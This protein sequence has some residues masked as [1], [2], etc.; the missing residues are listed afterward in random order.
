MV[1]CAVDSVTRMKVLHELHVARAFLLMA[2][3]IGSMW[4]GKGSPFCLAWLVNSAADAM[5]SI[6]AMFC[7]IMWLLAI[8][9]DELCYKRRLLRI[10][11]LIF[12]TSI[13]ALFLFSISNGCPGL[14][15]SSFKEMRAS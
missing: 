10:E 9:D 2:T 3:G 1:P 13:P 8:V 6:E 14:C 11:L 4:V 7:G 15:R 5:S 12:S